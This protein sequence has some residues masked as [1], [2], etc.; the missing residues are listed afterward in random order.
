MS[1]SSVCLSSTHLITSPVDP[2][3]SVSAED[4]FLQALG[5]E[6]KTQT[7][8]R[9]RTFGKISFTLGQG[10][11]KLTPTPKP[12]EPFCEPILELKFSSLQ[13]SVELAPKVTETSFALSLG[14][15][16]VVDH[17]NG[18]SLFP[19]LLQQ[20]NGPGTS[21]EPVLALTLKRES[22]KHTPIWK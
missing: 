13:T 10:S 4:E 21:G 5:F 19:V 9:D 15:V 18:D 2:R 3:L 7:L 11:L 12:D 14:S 8:T 6:D 20:R 22:V 16:E 1:A 17:Q